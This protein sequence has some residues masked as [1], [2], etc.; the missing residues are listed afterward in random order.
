VRLDDLTDL[1]A[2]CALI[3]ALSSICA[4]SPA[5]KY[6]LADGVPYRY[7]PNTAVLHRL[8]RL[9]TDEA[10]AVTHAIVFIEFRDLEGGVCRGIGDA[11]VAL[12]V[13]GRTPQSRRLNLGSASENN[14]SWNRAVRMYEVAFKIDPALDATN[15]PV[16]RADLKWS[17]GNRPVISDSLQLD[18]RSAQ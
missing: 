16:F 7:G 18:Q 15:R 6:R 4:C 3:A 8:S 12:V 2:K 1:G 10:G 14:A 9:Q 13:S 17:C 5:P 11:E